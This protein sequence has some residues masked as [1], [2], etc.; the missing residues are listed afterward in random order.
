MCK[1]AKSVNLTPFQ[2]NSTIQTDVIG[3]RIDVLFFLIYFFV[4]EWYYTSGYLN[5]CVVI[6]WKSAKIIDDFEIIF[7]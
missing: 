4:T 3:R 1:T 7:E 2:S 5:F 6:K